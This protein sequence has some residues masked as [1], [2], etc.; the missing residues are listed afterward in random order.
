MCNQFSAVEGILSGKLQ[1]LLQCALREFLC[2]EKR[3]KRSHA[4]IKIQAILPVERI[5]QVVLCAA[6][7]E[8]GEVKALSVKMYQSA[9]GGGKGKKTA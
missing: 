1:A 5:S 4:R 2:G 6:C 8:K 3:A 7:A 9:E